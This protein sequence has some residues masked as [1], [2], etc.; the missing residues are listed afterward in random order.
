MC[1]Y[2]AH[3]SAADRLGSGSSKDF[4]YNLGSTDSSGSELTAFSGPDAE[5]QYPPEL[6]LEPRHINIALD[7][8]VPREI[9]L[10]E[11]TTTLMSAGDGHRAIGFDA[12]DFHDLK[13]RDADGKPLAWT[14]DGRRL[15]VVWENA[16]KRGEERKVVVSYR[17]EKPASGLFFMSPTA[18]EPDRPTYAHTDHETE[19]ARHWLACVDLPAVRTTLEFHLTVDEKFTALANGKLLREAPAGKGRKTVS[20]RLDQRCPSYLI[21]FAVGDFVRFDD[22]EFEGVELSYFASRQFTPEDLKRAFGRTGKMLAWMTKRLGSKF[23]WPKYH[24]FALPTIGGAMENISLVS[25][26][27]IFVLDEAHAKEW[28]WVV[29][30]INVH[31]MA[32]TWFGDLVVCRDFAHAWLKESWATYMEQCWLED[33]HGDDEMRHDFFRNAEAY[34]SES[35]EVYSRPLVTRTFKSSWQMYDRH[36]YPGGACRLHTLRKEIGDEV[37]WSAVADYLRQ[38]AGQVVETEDFRR[39]L[40]R[41]SGRSLVKFFEQWC[42][43]AGYPDIHVGFE[44]DGS[45]KVGTFTIEQKQVER[46]Q[47]P[48]A[49]TTDV[50]WTIGGKA[51]TSEIK[52]SAAR[53]EVR[54]PMAAEPEMV[55]FDP[56]CRIL[57]KLD[58][59][60]GQTK[61]TR[62]LEDS[63]DVIGRILA[64]RELCKSGKDAAIAAVGKAW[65]KE[66][67]WGVRRAMALA[68]SKVHT[69]AAV[70]LMAKI[71]GEESDPKVLDMGA[72]D[73]AGAYRDPRIAA[74]LERR[75]GDA[76]LPPST[77]ASA[78]T[79][80]GLQRGKAPLELIG[81]KARTFDKY[82]FVQSAAFKAAAA[83]RRDEAAQL[84]LDAADESMES[85][86]A[87]TR[88]N[89]VARTGV[90]FRARPG[91]ASA[92]GQLAPYVERRERAVLTEKLEDLLRDSDA[93]VRMAAAR[94][95]QHAEAHGSVDLLEQFRKTVSHQESVAVEKMIRALRR[96][97]EP[98]SLGVRKEVEALEER[99]RKLDRRIGRIE[100]PAA[101][102]KSASGG[103]GKKKSATGK[104]KRPSR[105]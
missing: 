8:D 50:G 14:Y 27:D 10:A 63:P 104:K 75:L 84:L 59:N 89:K 34:F 37:F 64:A 102:V 93:N 94:G 74:A 11:I 21:C 39:V 91:L 66:K 97:E 33:Q 101:V 38:F 79:G 12:V 81:A 55:R 13:V 53:H 57:H 83:T 16:F 4:L 78:V 77:A 22:G 54:V 70:D 67:F 68:L 90:Q 41:H 72:F 58:F 85:V 98:G 30:Q 23:P 100:Q 52:L 15:A 40:E 60:P 99:L 17:V 51:F 49:L 18:S 42:Y 88:Q 65:K 28:T 87:A 56:N 62:Q 103:T 44:W 32:H 92:I 71:V 3:M 47:L 31:E 36:L 76:T 2:R 48:F 96:S 105:R 26:N 20:W 69:D 24:Q 86:S 95:L 45:T 61:L 80:L 35:D 5:R 25:W 43:T 82:G 9:A 1:L 7:I 46:K 29:D 6:V 73:W 19:R